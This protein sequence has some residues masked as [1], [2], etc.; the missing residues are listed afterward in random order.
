MDVAADA[1]RYVGDAETA[2]F[3]LRQRAA[4]ARVATLRA[5]YAIWPCRMGAVH[6]LAASAIA[7]ARFAGISETFH[8]IGERLLPVADGEVRG[9]AWRAYVDAH[10]RGVPA[11]VREEL[12]MRAQMADMQAVRDEG[13]LARF[14]A[15]AAGR[16]GVWA[17]MREHVQ[18]TFGS[19]ITDAD[20]LSGQIAHESA[21]TGSLRAALGRLAGGRLV[22]HVLGACAQAWWDP[23]HDDGLPGDRDLVRGLLG[24]GFRARGLVRVV[25]IGMRRAGRGVERTEGSWSLEPALREVLGAAVDQL[26]PEVLRFF[27]RMGDYTIEA[28]VRLDTGPTVALGRA[29]V[30]LV[31]QGMI[32]AHLAEVPARF[33]IFRREDGALHFLREFH[34]GDVVRVFDS[35]FLVAQVDG[36]PTLCERFVDLGLTAV[37]DTQI[38]DG[39]LSMR[40][41]ALLRGGRRVPRPPF[42]VVFVTRRTSDPDW[43]IEVVGSLAHAPRSR[44]WTWLQHGLL[45][46]PRALGGIRYRAARR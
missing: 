46:R 27:D 29:A 25:Q 13:W 2:A 10:R 31:G 16:D 7:V 39:G 32:E 20:A 3:V 37:F 40:V 14:D 17:R 18:A 42:D 9:P 28:S 5:F 11:D 12:W 26:D 43:P 35:D 33:R 22:P 15:E 44:L 45:R 1:R 19:R 30:M 21:I 41:G 4:R 24:A 38:V 36:V 23:V 34:C 8:Q 6:E